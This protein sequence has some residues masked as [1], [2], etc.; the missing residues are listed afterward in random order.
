VRT[1]IKREGLLMLRIL[2]F[3][4]LSAQS[5][6]LWGFH[7]R[8]G[9]S[10]RAC[11]AARRR[12]LGAGRKRRGGVQEGRARRARWGGVSSLRRG[13]RTGGAQ[14]GSWPRPM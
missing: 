11:A 5:R 7:R 13:K 9:P 3:R 2:A 10:T 4:I 6:L 12:R 8:H 14:N 1:V